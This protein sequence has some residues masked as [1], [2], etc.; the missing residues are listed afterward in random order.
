MLFLFACSD[1]YGD[2][3]NID[4]VEEGYVIGHQCEGCQD[5]CF[6]TYLINFDGIYKD[7][8]GL[9]SFGGQTDYVFEKI[10]NNKDPQKFLKTLKKNHS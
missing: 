6:G 5:E 1:G 7:L 4:I 3:E 2:L 10:P 8:S 9:K